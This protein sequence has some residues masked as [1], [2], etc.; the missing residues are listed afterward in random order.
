[1]H[2]PRYFCPRGLLSTGKFM[3]ASSNF[4]GQIRTGPTGRTPIEIIHLIISMAMGI[5][6]GTHRWKD[7]YCKCFCGTIAAAPLSP[8]T[9]SLYKK[10]DSSH[11]WQTGCGEQYAL[12]PVYVHARRPRGSQRIIIHSVQAEI[13]R[14]SKTALE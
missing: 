11:G 10:N 1:M 12:H 4:C 8:D 2:A 14:A 7:G 13:L 6:R 9:L 5:I 3:A